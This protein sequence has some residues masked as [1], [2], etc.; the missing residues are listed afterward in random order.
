MNDP[1]GRF[2]SLSPAR[3]RRIDCDTA[4]TADSWPMIRLCS[5]SSMWMSFW[6]SS[7]VSLYTGMPVQMLRT[8]A[9][10]SSSTSSNRSTP[11]ALTS[12]S[13][14]AFSSSS[15]FSW[16]RRRPASSKRCSSTADFLAS[17]TSFSFCSMSRRSGGVA[18][19]LMRRRLPASSMRSIALSGRKRSEM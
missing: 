15:D 4:A 2:G 14:A 16:S 7:S 17:W 1:L 18:M 5:S 11:S 12:A 19:R 13:L 9:T 8:S 10:A 3:V 6:V